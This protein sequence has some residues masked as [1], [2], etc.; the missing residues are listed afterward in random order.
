MDALDKLKV[1]GEGAQFEVASS[2]STSKSK[3]TGVDAG[4][5]ALCSTQESGSGRS[6]RLLRVLQTNRCDR[7]CAYCPLRKQNDAVKRVKFAPEELASLYL[8]FEN[9]RLADG[10]FLSSGSDGSPDASMEEVVK[11][12]AILREKYHYAGYIHL[13]V[14]PGAS[15]GLVEEAARLANRLSVNLE[16]PNAERLGLL[17]GDKNFF[18]DIITRMEWIKKLRTERGWLPAGQSTQLIV[19]AGQETDREILKTAS[20][21]YRDLGLNRVYYGAFAPAWGTPLEGQPGAAPRRQ[22]RLYQSDWLLSEY[23]FGFEEL[24]FAAGGDLPLN[25]DP[26]VAWAM[27]HPERF[28]VEIN[29]AEPEELLRIPGIGPLSARRIVSLRAQYPFKTLAALKQTGAVVSRARDFITINGGYHGLPLE[30]LRRAGRQLSQ[31]ISSPT[32]VLPAFR[33]LSLPLEWSRE[34]I[35]PPRMSTDLADLAID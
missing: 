14:L 15:F 24:P 13:K 5:S 10:L 6:T 12:A 22:Q 35:L 21:L 27:S 7:G 8:Q 26:K 29:R 33:Q 20:W 25:L 9:R 31:P 11:T 16:A 32:P 2:S 18:K 34:E 23:G 19:G 4:A 3:K 28:P 17:D 30:L 1:L